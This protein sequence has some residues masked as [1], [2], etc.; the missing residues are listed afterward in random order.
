MTYETHKLNFWGGSGISGISEVARLALRA[1]CKWGGKISADP[2]VRRSLA[3]K[4]NRTICVE[5][6][7][8]D[9]YACL[10]D[11]RGTWGCGPSMSAAIGDLVRTHSA[12]LDLQIDSQPTESRGGAA[13]GDAPH[14]AFPRTESDKEPAKDAASRVAPNTSMPK[15]ELRVFVNN[16][17]YTF[18]IPSDDY[19]VS[20]LRYGAPWHGPQG[21]ATSALRSIMA[22]LDAAR[23]VV[24]A[25]RDAASKLGQLCPTVIHEA[26]ALHD[27][28]VDDHEPPSAW[29]G[30]GST[31]PADA[32]PS[33]EHL[34]WVSWEQHVNAEHEPNGRPMAWPPPPEVLAFWETGFGGDEGADAYCSVVA[35]VRAPSKGAAEAI[36]QGA[37]M[38]GVGEWR[39]NREYDQALPPGDR[40]PPPQWSIEQK[41]WPWGKSPDRSRNDRSRS[42]RQ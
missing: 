11:N 16:G 25:A 42:R 14:A 21:E 26:V 41:R 15:Q 6:R 35:L 13:V 10:S 23:V 7:L 2:E 19:R 33:L 37:W 18:V 30:A 8:D 40:F 24:K 38:P 5:P 27:R 20:I 32:G 31:A 12:T 17:K 9:F 39:Y 36:I 1:W 34:R 28:L 29:C 3:S 22:E 4:P